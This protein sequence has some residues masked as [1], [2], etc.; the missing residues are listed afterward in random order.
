MAA[1]VH[2]KSVFPVY[3][4]LVNADIRATMRLGRMRREVDGLSVNVSLT[5][6]GY[7]RKKKKRGG[8]GGE[9]R[10]KKKEKRRGFFSDGC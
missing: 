3:V 8:G 4:M 2:E 6:A 1:I 5:K 10:K 9:E 7:K